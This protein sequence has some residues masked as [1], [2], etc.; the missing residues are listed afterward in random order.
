MERQ[1]ID[2]QP[3]ISD[4]VRGC[5]LGVA[6]GDALGA[7]FEHVL[8]GQQNQALERAG[9]QIQ[10][11]HPHGGLPPGSWT[12]DTAMTLAS[13]R[14]FLEMET[15]GTPFDEAFR[16][17]FA[18]CIVSQECRSPG[19]TVKYAATFGEA[20]VN[21]WANGALMRMSP[22]GL[23]AYLKG[24]NLQETHS[25]AYRVARLTHGHPMATYPAVAMARAIVSILHGDQLVPKFDA[26]GLSCGEAVLKDRASRIHH[27]PRE[28]DPKYQ[29]PLEAIPVTTGLWMWR[30]V[31]EVC[32]G[33]VPND[34]WVLGER[35]P[36]WQDLPRF[37]E[38]VLRTVNSSFDRDTA[39]AVAGAILG[40]Y[41]GESGIPEEWRTNVEKAD[42]ITAVADELIKTCQPIDRETP[43]PAGNGPSIGW[44]H[45]RKLTT[46]V[47][48]IQVDGEEAIR[49]PAGFTV[50]AEYEAANRIE[51]EPGWVPLYWDDR[52]SLKQGDVV[53][54]YV[55]PYLNPHDVFYEE[56]RIQSAPYTYVCAHYRVRGAKVERIDLADDGRTS[57]KD[58]FDG[59]EVWIMRAS[60]EG[61][62]K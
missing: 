38:G 55:R 32:L 15:R 20:D 12:D 47:E 61:R 59:A 54:T 5:L 30:Q 3:S 9:G 24:M 2:S 62:R 18:D 4:R 17:A 49:N 28:Y 14:A 50:R 6:I 46:D 57:P 41:W 1:G 42:R 44:G 7:P 23:Y 21:S 11:F 29:E 45:G 33:L 36:E 53:R 48:S 10:D 34:P 27:Y 13:C 60:E 35:C 56:Y 8:P 37:E 16:E 51:P 43:E 26:V 39:G 19:K 58:L 40:T 52:Y 22:V 25:T 31:V